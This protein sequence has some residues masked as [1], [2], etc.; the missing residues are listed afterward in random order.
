M[1]RSPSK[2]MKDAAARRK[3]IENPPRRRAADARAAPPRARRRTTPLRCRATVPV[4]SRGRVPKWCSASCRHR[5]WEQRRAAASGLSA[6][7]AHCHEDQAS[8]G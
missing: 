4:P 7:G 2:R 8:G 5:A 1:A 3:Q 6:I